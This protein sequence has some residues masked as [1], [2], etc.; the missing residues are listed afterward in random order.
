MRSAASE[1]GSPASARLAIAAK[2]SSETAAV[3]EDASSSAPAAPPLP[4][5]RPR[6]PASASPGGA[7]RPPSPD[8]SCRVRSRAEAAASACSATSL[9]CS[10]PQA[11]AVAHPGPALARPADPPRRPADRSTHGRP[12]MLRQRSLAAAACLLHANGCRGRAQ[13]Q[14]S[15]APRYAPSHSHRPSHLLQAT[16]AAL[17]QPSAAYGRRGAAAIDPG[18]RRRNERR[19]KGPVVLRH[20]ITFLGHL[21]A[22][23][24]TQQAEAPS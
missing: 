14:R 20:E 13:R 5:A 1:P 12:P 2:S 8:N 4:L 17:H 23:K 9:P 10:Q 11:P 3:A 24:L 22:A 15:P 18:L 16:P 21:T 19:R 6:L 7:A